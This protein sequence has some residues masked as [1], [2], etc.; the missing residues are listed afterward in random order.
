MLWHFIFTL[1]TEIT[2]FKVKKLN[3]KIILLYLLY[4]EAWCLSVYPSIC[5]SL[6][7]SVTTGLIGFYSLGNIPT[8]PVMVLGNFLGGAGQHSINLFF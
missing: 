8:G 6:K 7:I 2:E 1:C 3:P 4:K 5:L